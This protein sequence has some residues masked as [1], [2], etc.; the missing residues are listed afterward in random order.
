MIN[1]APSVRALA[2]NGPGS[3]LNIFHASGRAVFCA[4]AEL[5]ICSATERKERKVIGL[6]ILFSF[7]EIGR[8][9]MAGLICTGLEQF[10][11]T[12][13][14]FLWTMQTNLFCY[15]LLIFIKRELEVL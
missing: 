6:S 7:G 12:K 14:S 4:L 3:L 15:T 8:A 5:E 13:L 9:R 10:S 1:R 2:K 11:S